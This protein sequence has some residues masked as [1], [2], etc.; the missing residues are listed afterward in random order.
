MAQRILIVDDNPDLR[1]NVAEFLRLK[2]YACEEADCGMLALA[3]V[4]SGAFS[5]VI[6]DIGLPDLDGFE[7]CEKIRGDG[8]SIPIL[9]LTARDELDDRVKGLE[10]GAD[11]YL[12]K[13]FSLRELAARIT[14]LLRRSGGATSAVMSVGPLTLR[15]D[16]ACVE[17]EGRTLRLTPIQFRLLKTLMAASPSVVS[18]AVLERELWGDEVPDSDSL[19]STMWALRNIVD[20]PFDL[21]LI[22]TVPGFGWAIAADGEGDVK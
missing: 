7:V 14:A 20:K 22:R 6:L 11:D 10:C 15:L 9:M 5:C 3:Q 12:I 13:P 19:R 8:D 4:K 2:G 16:Q 21:K 18:R 17:R 1:G